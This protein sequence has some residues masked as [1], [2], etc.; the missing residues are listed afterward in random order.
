[1]NVFNMKKKDIKKKIVIGLEG[2]FV[3]RVVKNAKQAWEEK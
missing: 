2:P 3:K 1:M